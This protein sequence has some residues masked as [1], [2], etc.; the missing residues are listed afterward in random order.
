MLEQ[1]TY[2]N[3]KGKRIAFGQS[4]LYANT[5][6]VRNYEWQYEGAGTTVSS[7]FRGLV[8]KSIPYT[9]YGSESE[10]AALKNR[11]SE[12]AEE[13][14]LSRKPGRLYVGNAYLSCYITANHKEVYLQGKNLL[15]GVL[16]VLS[17]T[18]MWITEVKN[19]FEVEAVSSGGSGKGYSYNYPYNYGSDGLSRELKNDHYAD[20]DFTMTLYG[21]ASNPKVSIGENDYQLNLTIQKGEYVTIDSRTKTIEKMRTDGIMENVFSK[22]DETAYIFQKIPPGR[23]NVVWNNQFGFDITFYMERSEPLWT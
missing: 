4:S 16:N 10:A 18:D 12:I 13:D 5:N 2:I 7:F 9:I 19:S 3:H 6:D 23:S 11:L 15:S 21:Y 1:L 14:V 20:C 8:D 17:L 22:R